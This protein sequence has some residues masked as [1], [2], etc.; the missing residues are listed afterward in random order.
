MLE[1][2]N[3]AEFDRFRKLIYDESGITFSATNR[4]I[5]DSRI[6]ELLR[7]KN[8][9]TPADYYNLVIHNTEEMKHM[10]D[11]VTTNLTRFFRN[12]PHFDALINYVI[13][14]VIENKKKTGDRTI[15]IW[16]AGCSTGEEPYTIAMVLK[17]IVPPGYNFQITASDISLKSLMV[18]Q[19]GFY[20]D[21][22]IA[23]IPTE[24]LAK[25]FTKVEGGYQVKPELRNTIRFDYHNLKNDSGL[26]N[27]DVV[28]CRNV[29]IYFDEAAQKAVMDRFWTSMAQQS[30][31]FIGHSESLFGMN[32]QFEFLK[33]EWAC[34]YQKNK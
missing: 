4:S 5:L 33:T 16:S 31:L 29:I 28:F 27:L 3:D 11:S 15:K 7:Q 23:G 9:A 10:L 8:L 26:R 19:Q 13:P 20:T 22:K 32:T 18:G 6:K 14:H 12:Q 2:L 17:E 25:Y 1:V 24:Y 30:Y 34:L 21:A